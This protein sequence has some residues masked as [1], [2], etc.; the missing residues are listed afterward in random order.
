MTA[1]AAAMNAIFADANMAADAVFLPGGVPPGVACRVI[2]KAPDV[3]TDFGQGRFRS[4]TTV[5]D[6]RVSQIAAPRPG[7]GLTIGADAFTVQ[8]EPMRDAERLVWTLD[9]VPV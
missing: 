4:A 5:V 2:R 7:D 1:F 8:G 6:V 9:L 3:T